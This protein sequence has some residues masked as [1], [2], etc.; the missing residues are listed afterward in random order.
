MT[1][2]QSGI[3]LLALLS[4]CVAAGAGAFE[5][6]DDGI[7]FR[8]DGAA[9]GGTRLLRVT[10]CSDSI[11]R[12]TATPDRFFS[13]RQSLMVQNPRVRPASWS[14]REQKG[15]VTLSTSSLSVRVDPASGSVSFFDKSGRP[16]LAER[17]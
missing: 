5:K 2:I 4:G 1:R 16:V 6:T 7:L 11:I 17:P 9:E 3:M 14:A 15:I 12:V 13:A 10:V 8:F